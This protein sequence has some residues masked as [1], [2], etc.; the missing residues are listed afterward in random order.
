MASMSGNGH[1]AHM[2]KISVV[3]TCK[4]EEANIRRCLES[5]K[6]ADEIVIND[7]GSTDKTLDICREYPNC[8][9]YEY[10]YW[11]GSGPAF[12]RSVKLAK[13]NMVFHID[14]DEEVSEPLRKKIQSLVETQCVN[15]GYRVKRNTFF[16]GQKIKY[17]SWQRDYTLRLFNRNNGNYNLK[18]SHPFVELDCEVADIHEE[19]LHYTCQT[20]KY[21]EQRTIYFC[22]HIDGSVVKKHKNPSV[23]K[24]ILRGFAKFL[25]MYILNL[26]FLDG[27]IGLILAINSSYRVYLKHLTLWEMKRN[28]EK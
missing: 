23:I 26:G 28:Q 6:W 14:A 22:D 1:N 11:D 17:S 4:N 19:L 18:K 12:N 5:V 7:T 3:I 27:K 25:K 21:H 8:S 15:K 20:I 16:L 2:N 24:A 9:I 10:N 13:H